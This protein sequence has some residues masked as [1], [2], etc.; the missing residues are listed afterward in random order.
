MSYYSV[1]MWLMSVLHPVKNK[2]VM[3]RMNNCAIYKTEMFYSL[4]LKLYLTGFIQ[5]FGVMI[6][7]VVVGCV[8]SFPFTPKRTF[9]E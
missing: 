8:F 6:Q 5:K 3:E 4:Q 1:Y 7:H 2:N 9:S